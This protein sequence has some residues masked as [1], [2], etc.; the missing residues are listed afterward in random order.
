M[1]VHQVPILGPGKARNQHRRNSENLLNQRT[2]PLRHQLQQIEKLR[3]ADGRRFG[4]LNQ[5]LPLRLRAA[6]LKAMA[7]R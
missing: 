7:M 1:R 6:T 2:L 3:K 5:R 4:A